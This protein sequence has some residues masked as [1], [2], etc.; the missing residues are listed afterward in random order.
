MDLHHDIERALPTPSLPY[1]QVLA[2]LFSSDVDPVIL[3]VIVLSNLG[4]FL[5]E[6]FLLMKNSA[7][8]F[9]SPQI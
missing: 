5:K 7:S 8:L 1:F 9:S 6:G 3:G 4:F 2:N